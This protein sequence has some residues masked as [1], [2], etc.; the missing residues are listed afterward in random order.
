MPN[1]SPLRRAKLEAGAP[2]Q[3][4]AV[5]GQ[6][7]P[8][9][10][11]ARSEVGK[12]VGQPGVAI[13]DVERRSDAEPVGGL[14]RERGLEVEGEQAAANRRVALPAGRIVI[15]GEAE[16][17]G[18]GEADRDTLAERKREGV[19]RARLRAGSDRE[20]TQARLPAPA[21][22]PGRSISVPASST[23]PTGRMTVA[24]NTASRS[25]G[26][27]ERPRGSTT[28]T[29]RPDR[30]PRRNSPGPSP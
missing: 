4:P 14:D 1:V 28:A 20:A 5:A 30:R 22:P 29:P 15:A 6:P 24:P 11:R 8:P 9:V 13:L 16:R 10:G 17:R 21:P 23:R 3:V 25:L 12:R 18:D 19:V 27:G 2:A 7:E 26:A